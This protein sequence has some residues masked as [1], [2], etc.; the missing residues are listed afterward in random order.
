M[1]QKSG[2]EFSGRCSSW[3]AL[4][5]KWTIDKEIRVKIDN[6]AQFPDFPFCQ[7]WKS[8]NWK[9]WGRFFAIFNEVAAALFCV[10]CFRQHDTWYSHVP[11]FFPLR[12]FS[13][14]SWNFSCQHWKLCDKWVIKT[15]KNNDKVIVGGKEIE[16]VAAR[17]N[18]RWKFTFYWR[19]A[20]PRAI[21]S[22]LFSRP[23][24]MILR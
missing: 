6:D 1:K 24:T 5:F 11:R 15:F 3:R 12:L 17:W 4:Y 19:T 18:A 16:T 2:E 21:N 23:L 10:F 22:K 13:L 7:R 9:T 20:H 8:F 14:L